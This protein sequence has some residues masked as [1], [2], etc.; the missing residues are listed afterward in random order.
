MPPVPV[1]RPGI[2]AV[3]L[4]ATERPELPALAVIVRL[5]CSVMSS[6]IASV[7]PMLTAVVIVMTGVGAAGA[8]PKLESAAIDSVA[9]APAVPIGGRMTALTVLLFVPER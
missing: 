3:L 9:V 5:A 2:V 6:V 8:G 7:P 4:A 1:I